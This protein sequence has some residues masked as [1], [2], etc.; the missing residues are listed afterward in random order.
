MALEAANRQRVSHCEYIIQKLSPCLE[1]DLIERTIPEQG[2]DQ[3]RLPNMVPFH[4]L[5]MISY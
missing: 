3:S 5:G 2:R 1:K 4:K